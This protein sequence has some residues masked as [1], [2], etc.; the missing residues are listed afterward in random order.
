MFRRMTSVRYRVSTTRILV[1]LYLVVHSSSHS[2]PPPSAVASQTRP[3][4]VYRFTDIL[5]HRI[6]CIFYDFVGG[7]GHIARPVPIHE[8]E[9]TYHRDGIRI[10]D[11]SLQ[12][13]QDHTKV[14]LL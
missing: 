1:T 9:W 13:F 4:D 3:C 8:N 5:K 14:R 2:P 10:S 11:P 6:L 7:D 12:A